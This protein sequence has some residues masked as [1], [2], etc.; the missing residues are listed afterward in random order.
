V[1]LIRV[2]APGAETPAVLGPAGERFDISSITSDFDGS[3]FARDG[4]ADLQRRWDSGEIHSLPS[5][6]PAARLGAPIARPGHLLCAGLNYAD[7][8]AESNMAIPDEPLLFTKAP[9]TVVGPYDDVPMPRGATKV[10]YEVELGIV[11]GS[12]CRYL[13]STDDVW[14]HIAGFVLSNDLSER[15]FQLERGGQWLKG[16]SCEAFNPLGPWLVTRDEVDLA[17]GLDLWLDV[18][19][20]RRQTGSTN[21]LIFPVDVLIHY[22][23][24]FLVLDP[25]DLINTGTPPGVAMGMAEP[26]WVQEGDVLTLG[27]SGLGE[28]RTAFTAAV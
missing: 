11:I 10:D 6:D 15:A 2:G 13:E 20:E 27:I 25:G 22:I 9:N 19:G 1:K 7:H 12:T 23:S 8:A 14:S 21:S 5:L 17:G 24:Q 16:K 4:L 3:F 28:Q 18:N 26:A